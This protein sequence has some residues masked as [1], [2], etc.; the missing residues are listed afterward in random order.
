MKKALL[1]LC[2]MATLLISLAANAVIT[3]NLEKGCQFLTSDVYIGY[4]GQGI[5]LTGQIKAGDSTKHFAVEEGKLYK[6]QL[7]LHFDD[8]I[9]QSNT[10]SLGTFTVSDG[11]TVN[12][13]IDSDPCVDLRMSEMEGDN[14]P[15]LT[16]RC[17][18]R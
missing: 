5:V 13:R 12:C 8:T 6:V 10:I 2:F 14:L 3:L 16:G 7:M 15:S 17:E 4:E 9:Y 1:G 11:Q 18:V